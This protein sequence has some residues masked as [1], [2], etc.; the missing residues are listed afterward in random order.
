MGTSGVN[1]YRRSFLP[2]GYLGI[3]D[4]GGDP[5][6]ARPMVDGPLLWRGWVEPL[7]SI[8]GDDWLHYPGP[9]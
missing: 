7:F 9:A 8:D 6:V 2:T 1:I 3:V 5:N 4:H